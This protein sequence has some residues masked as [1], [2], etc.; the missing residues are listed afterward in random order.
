MTIGK[1]RMTLEFLNRYIAIRLYTI[2]VVHV[3]AELA[4]IER[5][6]RGGDAT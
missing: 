6:K 2:L 5:K 4:T 1:V 3:E